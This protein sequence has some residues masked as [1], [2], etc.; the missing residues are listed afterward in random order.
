M[1]RVIQETLDREVLTEIEDRMKSQDFQGRPIPRIEFVADMSQI[2]AT[3]LADGHHL[4]HPSKPS[5]NSKLNQNELLN[6]RI[7]TGITS[8]KVLTLDGIDRWL[9]VCEV[10]ARKYLRMCPQIWKL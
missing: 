8:L 9:L 6:M 1:D 3:E 5:G 7:L 10:M 4:Q 2:H